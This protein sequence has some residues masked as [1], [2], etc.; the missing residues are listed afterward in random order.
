MKFSKVPESEIGI[1]I[2]SMKQLDTIE[3]NNARATGNVDRE[4]EE[5]AQQTSP[6]EDARKCF[7]AEPKICEGVPKGAHRAT[8]LQSEPMPLDAEKS[9]RDADSDSHEAEVRDGRHLT[10]SGV[11]Q[12]GEEEGREVADRGRRD[13]EGGKGQGEQP[14]GSKRG[15]ETTSQ[16][17]VNSSREAASKNKV[18]FDRPATVEG[19]TRD[20]QVRGV[21]MSA[22]AGGYSVG[23]LRDRVLHGGDGDEES[24]G[25]HG[26]VATQVTWRGKAVPLAKA[27]VIT[28]NGSRFGPPLTELQHQGERESH[29]SGK[30]HN[31]GGERRRQREGHNRNLTS[32]ASANNVFSSDEGS[33]EKM[34]AQGEEKT[35]AGACTSEKCHRNVDPGG[36]HTSSSRSRA[37]RSTRNGSEEEKRV[38]ERRCSN[39]EASLATQNN[40]EAKGEARAGRTSLHCDDNNLQRPCRRRQRARKEALPDARSGSPPSPTSDGGHGDRGSGGHGTT[41]LTRPVFFLADPYLGPPVA[42]CPRAWPCGRNV[43]ADSTVDYRRYRRRRGRRRVSISH[44][45]D[46]SRKARRRL[47]SGERAGGRGGLRSRLSEQKDASPCNRRSQCATSSSSTDSSSSNSSSGSGSSTSSSGVFSRVGHTRGERPAEAKRGPTTRNRGEKTS[48]ERR[49]RRSSRRGSIQRASTRGEEKGGEA[50]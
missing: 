40:S 12:E 45:S 4:T 42:A 16:G 50:W 49:P 35:S 48:E 29:P 27:I 7:T 44:E 34:P 33:A 11:A 47:K 3:H 14:H 19:Q 30:E 43:M 28:I 41:L 13:Y 9:E 8:S 20:I 31:I 23:K 21:V 38:G 18:R 46:T 6:Q 10:A 37:P 1:S 32:E 22:S 36:N 39:G 15:G 2:D 24:S 17:S 5:G 26:V 25:Q